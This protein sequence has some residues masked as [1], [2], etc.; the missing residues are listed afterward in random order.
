MKAASA[1]YTFSDYQVT[2]NIYA[3]AWDGDVINKA[4]SAGMYTVFTNSQ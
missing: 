4:T 2:K 1:Q 3:T